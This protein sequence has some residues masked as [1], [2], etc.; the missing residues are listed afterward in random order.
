MKRSKSLRRTR[1]ILV[2]VVVA[3]GSM[4]VPAAWAG[5]DAAL[6]PDALAQTTATPKCTDTWTNLSGGEWS[7]ATN[8][9]TGVVPGANDVACIT[10]ASKSYTVTLENS[11]SV[12]SIVLGATS[13]S[14][15][16]TLVE[17]GDPTYGDANVYLTKDFVI[18]KTGAFQMNSLGQGNV[19]VHNGTIENSG[20][21]ETLLGQGWSRYIYSNFVNEPG[22]TFDVDA[23]SNGGATYLSNGSFTNEGT[24][25]VGKSSEFDF[26]SGSNFSATFSAGTVNIASNKTTSGVLLL[27]STNVTLSGGAETGAAVQ[28]DGGS[29]TDSGGTGSYN[30]IDGGSISGKIPKGQT[31]SVT[32][33]GDADIRLAIN[34]KVTNKGTFILDEGPTVLSTDGGNSWISPGT[35]VPSFVNDGTFE[36]LPGNGYSRYINVPLTN[37]AKGT[38]DVQGEYNQ[39]VSADITNDGAFDMGPGAVLNLNGTSYGDAS[40]TEGG[41][42]VLG[43]TVSGDTSSEILQ[44]GCSAGGCQTEGIGIAGTLTVTTV[45]TVGAGSWQIASSQQA[46][47]EGAFSAVTPGFTASV[48][49][50]TNSGQVNLAS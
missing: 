35:G 40:F 16:Q 6:S 50:Q 44:G 48:Q 25:K 21:V 20:L 13:G 10:K 38:V 32:G 31:V 9:S 22:G 15:T 47:I 39:A 3:S 30:F 14:T 34:G 24:M 7:T 18:E 19:F 26:Q 1:G 33:N 29:V 2:G 46:P 45:G 17:Q 12:K 4:V 11:Y 41:S 8:W 37:G 36:L 49:N 27:G 5:A 28:L 23:A 42:A 43:V